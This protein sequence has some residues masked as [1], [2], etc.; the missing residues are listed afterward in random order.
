M[1]PCFPNESQGLGN[2]YTMLKPSNRKVCGPQACDET[3]DLEAEV[4]GLLMRVA[5]KA[6]ASLKGPL[7]GP[8][9][10]HKPIAKC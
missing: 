4:G 7:I 1:N 3:G 8:G 10:T 6:Q 5:R 9:A 2:W